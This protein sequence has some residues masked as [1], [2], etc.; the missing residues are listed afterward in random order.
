MRN[1][2]CYVGLGVEGEVLVQY[3]F[4]L[5]DNRGGRLIQFI[6]ENNLIVSNTFLN[7]H[8]GGYIRGSHVKIRLGIRCLTEREEICSL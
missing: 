2:N 8:R 5:R 6:V 1:L 4:Q 7:S 3:G